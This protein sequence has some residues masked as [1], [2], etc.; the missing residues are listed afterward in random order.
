[1]SL[2]AAGTVQKLSTSG[3]L[4]KLRLQYWNDV[5]CSTFTQQ[6]VDV[7]GE[8]FDAAMFRTNVGDMRM[9][10]ANSTASRITRTSRQVAL[11]QQ[12]FFLV[13]LQL[14][15]TSMNRQDGRETELKVG[16]FAL[17]DST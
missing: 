2:I 17:F 5:A 14:A 10:L 8:Q 13:H 16:D 7:S 6:T 4:P 15:G 9:A 3:V 11:S 12:A 1:M